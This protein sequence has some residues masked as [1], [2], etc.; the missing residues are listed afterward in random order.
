ME[1]P[2][3]VYYALKHPDGTK[4]F[5]YWLLKQAHLARKFYVGTYYIP[6]KKMYTAVF[7][8]IGAADPRAFVEVTPNEL[9][10]SYKMI[11]IKGCGQCCERNSGAVMLETEARDLGI[12]IKDK[13]AFKVTLVDGAEERVYR[14]DTRRAGQCAFF[15]RARRSCA[16]G[17]RKPILCTISYCGAFAERKGE[18]YVRVS[19]KFLPDNKVEMVF[20]RV[21]DS[22]WE[23]LTR[24]VRSGVNVW[25]AVA[26]LLRRR[27]ITS[28][29]G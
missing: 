8:R 15:N 28:R 22:E 16:L 26:E 21:T 23:E 3:Q 2:L 18:K 17:R 14:L 7:K 13:P 1:L 6:S 29:A 11:C 19:G 25:R 5:D 20:E 24:M 12:E 27:N 10:N 9:R 4:S